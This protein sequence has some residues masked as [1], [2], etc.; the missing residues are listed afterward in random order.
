MPLDQRQQVVRRRLGGD[1]V[2][3]A[4][5]DRRAEK[6]V[7]LRAV[8][9]RQGVQGQIVGGNAGVDHAAHVLPDQ[10]VVGEHGALGQRFGAAGVDELRQIAA[11]ELHRRRLGRI[12]QK[13]VEGDHAGRRRGLLLRRQPD[14]LAHLGAERG[15]GARDLGEAGV[16]R[17]HFGAGV[18]EDEGRL[19]RLEHEID[20]HQH[21]A[22]PRQREP[23]RREGVGIAR[24]D[25]DPRRPCRRRARQGPRPGDRTASSNS[26]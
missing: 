2:G 3:A 10:R 8:I 23:Q 20:R 4:D 26:A 16:G 6:G 15:G 5:I 25:G 13:L 14:E 1:D 11:G 24:Q 7:E 22:E 17:E 18:L 19:L 12:G 21:G 9:E